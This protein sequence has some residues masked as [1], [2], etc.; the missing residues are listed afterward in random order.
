MRRSA[1]VIMTGMFGARRI[2]SVG[3]MSLFCGNRSSWGYSD[4]KSQKKIFSKF[5]KKTLANDNPTVGY[6]NCKF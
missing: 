6:G 4:L 2:L 3:Q 5:Q 1:T